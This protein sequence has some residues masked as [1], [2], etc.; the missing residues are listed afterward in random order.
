[1][2]LSE[3][4]SKE[5][6]LV[7]QTE[8]LES[9]FEIFNLKPLSVAYSGGR[10]GTITVYLEFI[11]IDGNKKIPIKRDDSDIY[12]KINLYENGKLL[13]SGYRSYDARNFTGYDTLQFR[14]DFCNTIT[15]ATSARI[16]VSRNS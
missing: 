7:E 3:V 14:V 1:M 5:K 16:F 9:T 12:F 11:S 13:C 2:E 6:L 10:N 4:E 8:F 15:R